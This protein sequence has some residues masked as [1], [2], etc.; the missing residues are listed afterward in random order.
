MRM[1]RMPIP[2]TPQYPNRAQSNSLGL[3]GSKWAGLWRVVWA[4]VGLVGVWDLEVDPLLSLLEGPDTDTWLWP[5]FH[6]HLCQK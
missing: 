5:I 4:R 6:R 1:P 3:F 2:G